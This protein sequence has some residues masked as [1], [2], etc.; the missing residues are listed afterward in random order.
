[1]PIIGYFC[2][3]ADYGM[4]FSKTMPKI[5]FDLFFIKITDNIG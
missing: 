1:M 5:Y 2:I 4:L 3:L